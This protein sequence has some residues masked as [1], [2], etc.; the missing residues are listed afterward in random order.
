MAVKK[1]KLLAAA[2]AYLVSFSLINA[3]LALADS[4]PYFRAYGAD[5]FSGGWFNSS[6]VSCNPGDTATYQAPDYTNQ[7][8]AY[9]GAILGF[10]VESGSGSKGAGSEFG[11]IAMGL[12]EG[13]V[14]N[15]PLSKYGFGTSSSGNNRLDFANQKTYNVNNYWGGFLEGPARQAHCVQDYFGTLQTASP[16]AIVSA[17]DITTLADKQYSIKVVPNGDVTT[18]GASGQVPAGKKLT[19]FVDGNVYINS[20]ITYA[21]HN[22]TDVP[23]FALVVKGSIYIAPTVSRLDGLYIAQ[24]DLT[25]AN[26]VTA[27][28]GVIWTCHGN[29]TT[30]PDAAFVKDNCGAKLTFNGAVAAKQINLL[31]INGNV[32]S[33]TL[34]E[35]P[36]SGNIAEVFNFTPDMVIGGGFFN[37]TGG[38]AGKIESII[39]LPPVF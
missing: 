23:K 32:D 1:Y 13:D 27:D 37:T 17:P 15:P 12:I 35:A 18:I 34:G 20:D 9:K 26:V 38:S 28:T 39:S 29:T 22:E 30:D 19:I 16:E 33:A 36:N 3:G 10:A 24:P 6:A 2:F 4:Q 31:R 5:V 8:D 11:A 21:G 14:S 25:K 7:K